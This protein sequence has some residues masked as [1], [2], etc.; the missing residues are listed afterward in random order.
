MILFEKFGS[1]QSLNREAE[2][3]ARKD[4]EISLSALADQV[5]SC[6]AALAPFY[7]L[8]EAHMLAAE[9]LH[10]DD[11]YVKVLAKVKTDTARPPS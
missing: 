6:A 3:Y 10:G 8:I 1:H 5:D 2:R 9:R 4:V 11:T 7:Q